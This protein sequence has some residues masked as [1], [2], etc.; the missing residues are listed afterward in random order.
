M[1]SL[2]EKNV[3][4]IPDYTNLLVIETPKFLRSFSA[5]LFPPCPYEEKSI[6]LYYITRPD[7]NWSETERLN[8]L[9]LEIN[10]LITFVYEVWLGHFLQVLYA[11]KCTSPL[12]SVFGNYTTI[13]GWAYINRNTRC[14]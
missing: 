12:A 5:A 4:Q 11:N 7:P 13:E 3:V 9:M 14:F 1:D 2:I 6:G 8:Y 10:L